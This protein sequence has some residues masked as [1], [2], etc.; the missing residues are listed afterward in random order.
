MT[1][2]RILHPARRLRLVLPRTS[3]RLTRVLRYLAIALALL[4][5]P[6]GRARAA[7]ISAEVYGVGQFPNPNGPMTDLITF[8]SVLP[9][10]GRA[11]DFGEFSHGGALCPTFTGQDN[12]LCAS[13]SAR[14]EI[15][16]IPV[17]TSIFIGVAT[18][19]RLKAQAHLDWRNVT[20]ANSGQVW[21]KA[22]ITL[23][24]ACNGA[25]QTPSAGLRVSYHLSG[26]H[27]VSVS[28]GAVTVNAPRPF[29]DCDSGGHCTITSPTFH[30]PEGAGLSYYS[31]DLYPIIQVQNPM[32]HLG[33]TVQ[34]VSDYSHTFTLDGIDILDANGDPQPNVRVVVPADGGGTNDVFLTAAEAEE[35]ASASTTT[36]TTSG[37]T[38]S[39]TA[40]PCQTGDLAAA[41]CLCDLRPAAG[42][43]GVTLRGQ[44]GKRLNGLCAKLAKAAAATAKKQQR[45]VRQAGN[46]AR[47]TLAAVNGKKGNA[48]VPACRDGLRDFVQAVQADLAAAPN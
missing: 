48:V 18:A 22:S 29:E 17:A 10:G 46:L 40:P 28:D 47:Q 44:I 21:G 42:C 9:N 1:G 25:V 2:A 36:T 8:G 4:T 5:A 37:P 26:D 30:C 12:Y 11:F 34:A 24:L 19:I 23:P 45:L 33:W 43:E 6:T 39:T 31:I 35:L 38:T 7:D 20:A 27:S 15:D 14:V 3:A 41:K 13:A 32:S 16:R